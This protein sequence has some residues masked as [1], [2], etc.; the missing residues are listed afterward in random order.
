MDSCGLM[1]RLIARMALRQSEAI[2]LR[3]GHY[4]QAT[5]TLRVQG[6]NRRD[7]PVPEA[8]R[9]PLLRIIHG[10]EG[11]AY[12]VSATQDACRPLGER[13][14]QAYL[15]RLGERLGLAELTANNLRL[16][17][18]VRLLDA[19]IDPRLI[20]QATGLRSVKSVLKYRDFQS[21]AV[22]F[23][24]FESERNGGLRVA[25]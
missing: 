8:L 9:L 11:D 6:P 13:T 14:L 22:Q 5:N 17:C 1:I 4:D 19:G 7:L 21:P 12:I 10:R 3:V 2:A 15:N 24:F 20:Q 18:I 16:T 25:L 23:P